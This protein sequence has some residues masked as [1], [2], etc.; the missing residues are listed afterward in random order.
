[1]KN[2]KVNFIASVREDRIND[3]EDIA[4]SLEGLGCTIDNILTLSGV[5]TGS[6]SPGTSFTNL[7]IDGIKNIEPDRHIKTSDK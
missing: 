6:T 4:K 7:K 1:V 5:I 2:Q 3:I